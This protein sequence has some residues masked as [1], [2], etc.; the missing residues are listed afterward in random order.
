MKNRGWITLYSRMG[1]DGKLNKEYM[2]DSCLDSISRNYDIKV[3]Y[4]LAKD[5]Y[6]KPRF[7]WIDSSFSVDSDHLD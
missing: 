1:R 2:T 6:S 5:A 3:C 7:F 4:E